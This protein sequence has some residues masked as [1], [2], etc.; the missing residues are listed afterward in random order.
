ME[1]ESGWSDWYSLRCNTPAHG[2][3]EN[4]DESGFENLCKIME[5]IGITRAIKGSV[6]RT[7]IN[8]YGLQDLSFHSLSCQGL[9][10]SFANSLKAVDLC[11]TQIS[12]HAQELA[13]SFA[14]IL[15]AACMTVRGWHDKKDKEENRS[16]IKLQ[17]CAGDSM[18]TDDDVGVEIDGEHEALKYPLL[19]ILLA[20]FGA[21][22]MEPF[23][24]ELQE[25]HHSYDHELGGSWFDP[26]V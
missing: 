10:C 19:S 5:A 23:R 16:K 11:I 4:L 22:A 12:H 26:K 25:L 1:G 14:F 2:L 18:S 15:M 20:P 17:T 13:C 21:E 7:F 8:S 6:S 3:G 9:C 24:D